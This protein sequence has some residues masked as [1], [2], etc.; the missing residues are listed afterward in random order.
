[1]QAHTNLLNSVTGLIANTSTV[2][3]QFSQEKRRETFKSLHTP[4]THLIVL[5]FYDVQ[6]FLTSMS[7]LL[8]GLSTT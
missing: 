1:M 5:G 7:P 3:I 2:G 6:E 4:Q 8:S